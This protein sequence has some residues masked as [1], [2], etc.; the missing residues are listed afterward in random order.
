[1]PTLSK[2]SGTAGLPSGVKEAGRRVDFRVNDLVLQI[3]TKGYRLAWSR[4]CLCPCTS[5]NDQTD[6]PDPNC[7]L[8]TGSGW[9]M[10]APEISVAEKTI[11]KLDSLQAYLV[12]STYGVIFGIETG[13]T[14]KDNP[15]D[16]VVKRLEGQKSV[17]VRPENRLGY[18]DR[19]IN[20]DT[21]IVYSQIA[22]VSGATLKGRYPIVEM[23]LI[24]SEST[25]FTLGTDYN[26]V[27]GEISWISS[28]GDGT[29]VAMH[30][31]TYP[32]WRVIEHPHA[33][34]ATLQK[35]K[36]RNTTTPVGDP[37]D[38]PINAI[39]KLEFLL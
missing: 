23:N 5:V 21:T 19:L 20:L 13:L 39:C 8:C 32:H 2:K 34:R 1:M 14:N 28:P 35:L 11:G 6:Q 38:L 17:T 9:L 26:L 4:A 7:S 15:Y 37:T 29:R 12:G 3:E 24:R 16:Q 30:Y 10:F 36:K 22:D 31:L 33:T 27:N 18:N 25:V